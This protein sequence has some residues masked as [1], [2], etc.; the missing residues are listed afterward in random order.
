V[1][2]RKIVC[3]DGG[4]RHRLLHVH[5]MCEKRFKFSYSF[6]RDL[7][8]WCTRSVEGFDVSSQE[9]ALKV[10]QDAIDIFCC[11]VTDPG[12]LTD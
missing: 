7:I 8:K 6:V 11:S 9:S 3:N 1:N 10:F 4:G 12:M 2:E 5:I